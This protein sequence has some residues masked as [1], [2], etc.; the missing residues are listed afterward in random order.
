MR[1]LRSVIPSL[2][3]LGAGLTE[4]ASSW[5]FVEGS[6]SVNS[7]TGDTFKDKYVALICLKAVNLLEICD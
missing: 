3:L 6:I 1:F 7:K 5:S 2:L 4:A